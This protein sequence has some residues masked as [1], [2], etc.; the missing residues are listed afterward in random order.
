M[1]KA[2]FRIPAQELTFA[3]AVEVANEI[4]G[5]AMAKDTVYHSTSETIQTVQFKPGSC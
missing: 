3:N 2:L 5:A 1:L 4:E